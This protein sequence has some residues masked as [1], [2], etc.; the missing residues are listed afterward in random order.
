MTL[1]R[2]ARA[3]PRGGCLHGR[4]GPQGLARSLSWQWWS[5]ATRHG[6]QHR[7]DRVGARD[8]EELKVTLARPARA[9]LEA[10][11]SVRAARKRS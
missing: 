8:A 2:P 1:A 11:P 6:G 3:Q 7:V 10:P 4:R 9:Q 5:R